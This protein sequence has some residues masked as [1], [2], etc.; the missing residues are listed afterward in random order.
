MFLESDNFIIDKL[1]IKD[2]DN[3]RILEESRPWA[4]TILAFK[5]QLP[6]GNEFNYFEKLWSEYQAHD[7]FWCIYRKDGQFCGD[8]QLDRDSDTEYHLYIQIMDDARIE[9]FGTEMFSQLID[10]IVEKSG[11]EHLEF[12]LWDENDPSKVIFEELGIDLE[13]GEWVY[14][15]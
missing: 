6:G 10:R 2:K 14:D 12:E 5:T 8:V 15:I 13:D 1:Q 9:G 11:A 4:K 3:L 7:Y